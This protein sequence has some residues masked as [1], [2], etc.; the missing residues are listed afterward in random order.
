MDNDLVQVRGQAAQAMGTILHL[1]GRVVDLNGRPVDYQHWPLFGGPFLESE[2][3]SEKLVLK[4]GST[5]RTLDFKNLTV[6]DSQ[7]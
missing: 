2:V 3:D 1:E 4:H 5:R 7:N 6:V